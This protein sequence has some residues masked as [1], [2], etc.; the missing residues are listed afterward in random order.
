MKDERGS[1]LILVLVV[2]TLFS[3]LGMSVM[4]QVTTEKKLTVNTENR[5][6]ARY[7]AQSALTHFEKDFEKEFQK[8][9]MSIEQFLEKYEME[10]APIYVIG[11]EGER[12]QSIIVNVEKEG[13]I[14]SVESK[15]VANGTETTLEGIYELHFDVNFEE[16]EFELADFNKDDTVAVNFARNSVLSLGLGKLLSASLISSSGID[17]KFY[18]VPNDSIIGLK[19][20]G[21]LLELNLGDGDRFKLMENKRVIA[22]RKGVLLNLNVLNE[23]ARLN[24]LELNNPKDTNVL[25]NG[26]YRTL[27][28]LGLITVDGYRDIDFKKLAV[29]GNA[30]I[31]KEKEDKAARRY[32]SFSEGL[33]VNRTMIIG[34]EKNRRRSSL[35]L[36]GE[37]VAVEDLLITD[38]DIIVS[39]RNN[40]IYSG[41]NNLDIYVHG[42]VK[43]R[44]SCVQL[45]NENYSFRIFTK[46]KITFENITGCKNGFPGFFYAEGGAEFIENG[47]LM[48]AQE[49]KVHGEVNLDEYKII[50]DAVSISNY[51]LVPKGRSIK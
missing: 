5:M 38:T 33:F 19:L 24:V 28:L 2:I 17:D 9:D 8:E 44:N 23:S 41:E 39:E 49:G 27:N 40:S 34:D 43:I 20:L 36:I 1:T 7:L 11:S 10:D 3:V 48:N 37:V 4:A 32:F 25:I 12:E 35:G 47:T 42:N 26:Y 22:T 21:G 6:Q 31:K 18:I 16:K 15:G 45:K 51:R 50:D 13:S 30:M 29:L 14:I 46:G